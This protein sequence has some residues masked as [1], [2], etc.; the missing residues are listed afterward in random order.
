MKK[1]ILIVTLLSLFLACGSGDK[2]NKEEKRDI[3]TVADSGG[4][5]SLDPHMGNDGASLRINKQIYSRLVESN[6]NMKIIPGLAESWDYVDDRTVEF[7]LRKGVKFHNG[8]DFTAKDVKYSF[9]RMKTSP[10]IAFVLP[11]LEK[12][13]I[14]DDYKVQLITKEP[15]GPLLSH[16]SHPALAIVNQRA[17]EEYGEDYGQNP[18]GTGPYKFDSWDVGDKVTLIRNKEYFQTLPSFEKLVIRNIVEASSRSIGL[19]TGELDIALSIPAVDLENVK[20]NKNLKLLEKSSISYSYIGFNNEMDIFKNKDLRLAI[21]Y[22]IDKQSIVDVVLNGAGKVATSPLAPGVFGFTDRTKAYDYDPE[23]ARELLIKA[24]YEDGLKLTLTIY[25]GNSNSD[26]A[27]IV[28]AQLKEI[29]IDLAIQSYE[30]GTFFS[31]T[32]EGKHEMFLG[33]WGCVTGDA[34]YGLYS[35]Y[36]TAAKGA[37][38]NRTF[39]SN[40]K[41]DELLEKGKNSIVPKEREEIYEE[42]QK[43]IVEDAPEVMLYNRILGVGVQ[44]DIEG[45]NLHPV[46][47]HDFYPVYI[48]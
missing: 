15:F 16:L 39:Y 24:G 27:T 25:E 2:G 19:E 1:L 30:L 28:Q 18:V 12:V 41:V 35:V 38:G 29:G 20:N 48:K 40:P 3:L 33:S 7:N 43:I 36:N 45:L 11:P 42:I 4:P 23:K 13:E 21:N 44:G 34:D 5:K 37:P 10:R 17:I 22:A 6:G 14:I 26:V 9:E 31:Y 47:L 32:A 8:D 46:T